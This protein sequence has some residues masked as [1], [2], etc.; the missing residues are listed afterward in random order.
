MTTAPQPL[1]RLDAT[2]ERVIRIVVWGTQAGAAIAYLGVTAQP[3]AWRHLYATN[4]VD[5]VFLW[6]TS[7]SMVM[8]WVLCLWEESRIFHDRR[9]QRQHRRVGLL[10]HLGALVIAALAAAQLPN[11]VGWFAV[12]G[13]VSF[14]AFCTWICWMQTKFLPEEDQAVVDAILSREAAQ[15]AAVFDASQRE[16]R[17]ERLA[18]VVAS[19][20]YTLT[21]TPA[22]PSKP[23]DPPAAKWT[24]PAGKH[25]PYVYFIRNGNRMKIGTTT[26][27]KRRIRTLA[28]RAENIALLFEGDQ[29]RER[30][31][32]KQ[33]AE[34]RIGNTEWFAYEGA[35]AEFVHER[36]ALIAEGRK[37]K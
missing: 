35:L 30:E 7:L 34:H 20:G 5:T 28:L 31:F 17:R 3:A 12:L 21:D 4:R 16:Q 2:L 9:L 25:A 11:Q 32:H 14:A 23:A 26:E 22:K 6:L 10:C 19:L 36:T 24:V 33:F 29:R 37:L 1:G 8:I 18:A 13:T 15:R 27:L